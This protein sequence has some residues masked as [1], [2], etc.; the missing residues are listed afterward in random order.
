[1]DRIRLTRREAMAA[2]VT[3]L[4]AV[5]T[6]RSRDGSVLQAA[7]SGRYDLPSAAERVCLSLRVLE[8]HADNAVFLQAPLPSEVASLGRIGPLEGYFVAP[9]G[10]GDL[11]LFGRRSE[12]PV[13]HLDDLITNLRNTTDGETYPS[14]SLDPTPESVQRLQNLLANASFT[15]GA[16]AAARV[17]EAMGPQ[18][19]VVDG[20]PRDSRHAHIMVE[21][22][23]HMKKVSQGH[24]RLP[25]VTSYL[26]LALSSA[27]SGGSSMAR[28]WFHIDRNAPVFEED[29][30]IVW[31]DNC[32]VVLLTEKQAATDCGVLYD[33]QEDDPN[34]TAFANAM[35]RQL[36]QLQKIVPAYA[37]LVSLYRL[38][39]ILLA[40]HFRGAFGTARLKTDDYLR[41]YEPYCD[42]PMPESL[43]PLAN[44]LSSRSGHAA[45]VCGGVGMDM[46]VGEQSF[47]KTSGVLLSRLRREA[48]R[49]RPSHNTLVW[50][51]TPPT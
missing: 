31:L 50:A 49:S 15:D 40:I 25:G 20:V 47:L 48:L 46:P 13:L 33:V 41:H 18:R 28:F 12:R 6:G 16:S 26:Q 19:I 11:V 24:V 9:A 36:P 29:D 51:F 34:A 10:E 22:D 8:R 45:I 35:S 14:C 3:A 1:M 4:A 21:T 37:Q 44:H 7:E 17:C 5:A 38:R 2:A 27:A 43:P 23:Y 32:P 42:K 39:A 30:D